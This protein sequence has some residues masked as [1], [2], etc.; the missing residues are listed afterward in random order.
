M[1]AISMDHIYETIRFAKASNQEIT[2]DLLFE[3]HKKAW[4][5]K[6]ELVVPC[7]KTTKSGVE[8]YGF[9]CQ[10]CGEWARKRKDFFGSDLPSVQFST[11]IKNRFRS[12]RSDSFNELVAIWNEVRETKRT[13]ESSEWWDRYDAHLSS[14]VWREKRE[15]VL[16][17]DGHLCQGC[18]SRKAEEVHHLTYKNLGNEL[19]FELVSLCHECHSRSHDRLEDEADLSGLLP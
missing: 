5:C 13:A 9:Q 19:L 14:E 15:A 18:L 7:F 16:L 12:D 2:W 1:N 8:T 11:E 6:C 3:A 17:R 4:N 10:Y